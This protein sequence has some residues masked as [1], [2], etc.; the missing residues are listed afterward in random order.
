M[1]EMVEPVIVSCSPNC[2]NI[3]Y[4]VKKRTDPDTDFAP[5]LSTLREKLIR[6][7]RVIVYCRT[8]KTCA[9]LSDFFSYE[10][11]MDQYYP[12]GA[13]EMSD[14]RLFGMFHA[15]TPQSSKNVIG[16]SLMYSYYYA[17]YSQ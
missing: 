16:R 1:L 2:P 14:N 11:E 13:S 5:L 10:M 15:K 6:T 8:L 12:P 4:E 17:L 3:M 7:P 9:D